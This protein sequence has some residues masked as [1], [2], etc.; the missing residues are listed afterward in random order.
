MKIKRLELP[1]KAPTQLASFY[2]SLCLLGDAELPLKIGSSTLN[3]FRSTDHAP[4]HIAFNIKVNRVDVALEHLRS[5]VEIL[6]Y[7]GEEVV[8]HVSWSARAIYF[9]DLEGN[10]LEF[11]FREGTE[12]GDPGDFSPNDILNISEWAIVMKD[13]PQS[14]SKLMSCGAEVYSGNIEKFAAIGDIEGMFI[15]VPTGRNWLPTEIPSEAIDSSA[16]VQIKGTE[17]L[18]R[19]FKNGGIEVEEHE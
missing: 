16:L 11:I 3:F 7:Q 8:D 9:F 5:I 1:A 10:I 2:S 15:C 12:P 17:Y 18:I 13:V 6:N 19:S 14:C 4:F